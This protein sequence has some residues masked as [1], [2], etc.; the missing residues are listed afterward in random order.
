MGVKWRF[1]VLSCLYETD[2]SIGKGKGKFP[3]RCMQAYR[4]SR[5]MAPHLILDGGEWS[6]SRPSRFAPRERT[7]VGEGPIAGL[8]V[9]EKESLKLAGI[10][11]PDRSVRP[12]TNMRSQIVT[13]VSI[14]VCALSGLT[15]TDTKPQSVG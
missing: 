6:A 5:S 12:V 8:G 10:R 4:R 9:L 7:L 11:T 13:L 1:W 3:G 15:A 14:F 2:A